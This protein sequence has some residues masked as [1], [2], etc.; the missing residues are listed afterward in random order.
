VAQ[1][2]WLAREQ[3]GSLAMAGAI[4]KIGR[5]RERALAGGRGRFSGDAAET[6]RLFI[7]FSLVAAGWSRASKASAEQLAGSRPHRRVVQP[8][9]EAAATVEHLGSAF[10]F[11]LAGAGTVE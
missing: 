7:E 2:T 4:E 11:G 9:A 5:E 6:Q 8:V 1:L 10:Q 3:L